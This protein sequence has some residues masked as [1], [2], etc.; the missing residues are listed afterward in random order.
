MDLGTQAQL[1]KAIE[2]KTYRRIGDSKER[3]S[4]FRLICATNYDLLSQ[5]Q[6]EAFREDLYYRICVFPIIVPPLRN[7][8][9]DLTSLVKHILSSMRAKPVEIS[10]KAI[11]MLKKYDW[12]GNVRE[13]KNMLERALILSQGDIIMPC[14][15]PGLSNTNMKYIGGAILDDLESLEQHHIQTILAKYDGDTIKASKALGLSRAS[16]YRKLNK[17]K[18]LQKI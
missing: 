3:T 7:R 10:S 2:E 4:D 15:F 5:V 16:L 9:E 17:I 18:Q 6:K 11:E 12:P 13:L 1:L 14:H 8:L